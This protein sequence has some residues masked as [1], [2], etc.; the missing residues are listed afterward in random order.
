MSSIK[1]ILIYNDNKLLPFGGISE[2]KYK[3]IIS[4]FNDHMSSCT[5]KSSDTD[6]S[7]QEN[8]SEQFF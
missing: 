3:Y 6:L 7:K 4:S 5:R 1:N 8:G 2:K